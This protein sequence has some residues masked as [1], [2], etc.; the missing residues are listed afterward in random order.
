MVGPG[1]LVEGYAELVAALVLEVRVYD[2]VY[3]AD[4][5]IAL[6]ADARL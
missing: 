5:L 1:K 3:R 4:R 6:N 2:L